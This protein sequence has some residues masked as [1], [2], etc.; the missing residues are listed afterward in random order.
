LSSGTPMTVQHFVHEP[1][2]FPGAMDGIGAAFALSPGYCNSAGAG[3]PARS[4]LLRFASPIALIPIEG[5][6]R[7]HRKAECG[8]CPRCR[9]RLS[10]AA[11]EVERAP[12]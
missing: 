6:S 11:I 12:Q 4:A 9:R 7:R 3:A 10:R 8:T 5:G 1:Q 2:D